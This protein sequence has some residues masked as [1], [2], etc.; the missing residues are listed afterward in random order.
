[1]GFVPHLSK[2]FLLKRSSSPQRS[3]SACSPVI[4]W[5]CCFQY[6]TSHYEPLLLR[7]G[8]NFV[9]L[10][11]CWSFYPNYHCGR[12]KERLS[13]FAPAAQT[14]HRR[15]PNVWAEWPSLWMKRAAAEQQLNSSWVRKYQ[16]GII[17]RVWWVLLHENP[18]ALQLW[19]QLCSGQQGG[20]KRG[21]W[22][23]TFE[24]SVN[25]Y[26]LLLLLL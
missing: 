26:Q 21:P 12:T 7:T 5:F 13:P 19:P 20:S 10:L 15:Q 25:V 3:P 2:L 14:I 8:T 23:I 4:V 1:M 9:N 24:Q 6:F 16:T 11:K 18:S 17:I 22:L